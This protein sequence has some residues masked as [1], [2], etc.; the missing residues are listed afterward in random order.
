VSPRGVRLSGA[1]GAPL[2]IG[3]STAN[4]ALAG[5]FPWDGIVAVPR[6]LYP[7]VFVA[8]CSALLRGEERG[9]L[10]Y[11]STLL[12]GTWQRIKEQRI[13]EQRT[14]ETHIVAGLAPRGA[15]ISGRRA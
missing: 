5:K 2:R 14:E 15:A 13:K 4:R 8:R 10:S 12:S 1:P 7:G 9:L 3:C 11:T 6:V